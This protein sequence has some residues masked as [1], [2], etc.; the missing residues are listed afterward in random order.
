MKFGF[1]GAVSVILVF[2]LGALQIQ[3]CR[4]RS[5]WV[6]LILPALSFVLSILDCVSRYW[7][8]APKSS[9][10]YIF[11]IFNIPT[12]LFLIIFLFIKKKKKRRA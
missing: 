12:T 11:L 9:I 7:S 6:G 5:F 1:A 4:K 8:S 2:L 3:F 10:L